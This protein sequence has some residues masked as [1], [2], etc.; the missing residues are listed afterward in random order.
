[1]AKSN[2]PPPSFEKALGELEAIVQGMES[3]TLTLEESLQ[4]YQRGVELLRQCQGT[5]ATAE[6]RIQALEAGMAPAAAGGREGS[7]Q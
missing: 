5:L 1:M 3:G 7:A 6:E 4:A 2:P